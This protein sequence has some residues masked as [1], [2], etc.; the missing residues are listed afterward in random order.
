MT[1]PFDHVKEI[2]TKQRIGYFD[3]LT[4]DEK[5]TLQP[6][7]INRI[8]SMN[9]DFVTVVNEVQKYYSAMGPREIYLMYSQILPKGNYYNKYIKA[10]K[11]EAYEFWLIL[12]VANHFGISRTDA[13][14]CLRLYYGSDNGKIS[15]RELCEKYATDPK[16]I[17]KAK[18]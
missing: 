8:I 15:L 4:D 17:K 11:E 5:K 2:Y 10:A 13:V 7:M 9:Y 3:N 18:L 16:L 6:Y 14:D 12:L 1:T